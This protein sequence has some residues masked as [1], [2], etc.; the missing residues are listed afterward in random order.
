MKTKHKL[1]IIGSLVIVCLAL[2]AADAPLEKGSKT[3]LLKTGGVTVAE[4]KVKSGVECQLQRNDFSEPPR[5]DAKS[6]AMIA[7][8]RMILKIGTGTNM[9]KVVAEDIEAH[10]E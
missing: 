6:G 1:A 8:S 7:T 9:V 10:T 3:Y 4:L 2:L 5:V